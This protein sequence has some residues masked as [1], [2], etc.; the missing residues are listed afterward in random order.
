MERGLKGTDVKGDMALHVGRVEAKV[1]AIDFLGDMV[2]GVV[3]GY[4]K[5]GF[6]RC[7]V[8]VE[9]LICH[10]PVISLRNRL[11]SVAPERELGDNA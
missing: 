8:N 10:E 2:R 9:W 6:A 11:M 1:A 7:A 4:Q 3:D 5:P